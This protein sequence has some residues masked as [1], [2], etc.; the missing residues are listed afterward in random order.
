M[1]PSVCNRFVPIKAYMKSIQ[2]QDFAYF[3]AK[4]SQMINYGHPIA[5]NSRRFQNFESE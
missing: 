2:I 4:L 3:L 5:S 1:N